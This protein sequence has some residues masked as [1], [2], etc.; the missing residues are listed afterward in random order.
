MDT[1][2]KKILKDAVKGM[3]PQDAQAAA[4]W[5][6]GLIT[7][8][9]IAWYLIASWITLTAVTVLFGPVVEIGFTQ[10]LSVA[11]FIYLI[12]SFMS[13]AKEA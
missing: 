10:I 5:F 7:V 2:A 12:R 13:K 6:L 1:D 8:F 4:I 9:M 11:W 3:N